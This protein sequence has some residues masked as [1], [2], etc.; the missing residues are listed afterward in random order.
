MEKDEQKEEKVTTNENATKKTSSA[1]QPKKAVEKT[2][3][4][5]SSEKATKKEPVKKETAKKEPT[6]KQTTPKK[7]TKTEV[8]EEP[9]EEPKVEEKVEEI[10]IVKTPE[11]KEEIVKELPKTEEVKKEDKEK[12]ATKTPKKKHTKAIVAGAIALVAIIVALVVF[13]VCR[14]TTIDLS[15]C[16]TV[17]YKGVSGKAIA[18]VKLNE[19][20]LKSKIKD[21]DVA[22]DIVKKVDFKFDN[23]K[24]YAN[25]DELSIEVK[26]SSS[27]LKKNKLKLKSNTVKIKVEG[28]DEAKTLDMAKYIKVEY[29]GFNKHATAEVE[30]DVDKMEEELGEDITSRLKNRI[31]LNIENNENLENGKDL[32][33]KVDIDDYYLE[34]VG[35]VLESD[36]A[37]IEI[38]GLDD[39]NEIEAFKDIKVDIAG[40]SPN[41]SVSVVNN[42]TD[43]FLKTVEYK[44]S[45][46]TGVAN[47]E[48]I[49]ITVVKWDEELFN[50]KKVTLK[51]TKMEYKVEGQ[52]AYIFNISEITDTVKN[53][54]KTT[55]VSKATSKANENHENY[56]SNNLK[57]WLRESTDYKY[58]DVKAY[59]DTDKDLSFGTPEVASMYLL[60]KKADKNPNQINM[61]IGIVKVPCKSAKTGATYTW[62]VTVKAQ[63][64]SLKTDGTLSDNTNYSIQV[65]DGKDEESAYQKYINSEK[66]NYDVEKIS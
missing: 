60:T 8:K 49:T 23:T 15:D 62:Y 37:K 59:E 53:N 28:L 5:K 27:F 22:K 20:A 36:I 32:E 48:T 34:M 58:A 45:K 39:A 38:E 2:E 3:T 42:S 30:L 18:T 13:L 46:S 51:E 44:P 52:S 41:L 47:G 16:F 12:E 6:K 50:E 24:E 25:G 65:S 54:L 11:I 55:F 64:A 40:M 21:K 19:K 26:I 66:N 9:K 14:T 17:E 7:E 35:V 56:N 31:R 43:E 63:N 61:I 33:V 4:K 29:Q 57:Y 1:K 10:E